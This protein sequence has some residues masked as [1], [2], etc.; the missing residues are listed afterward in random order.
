MYIS[1]TQFTP[2]ISLSQMA[3]MVNPELH[4]LMNKI[5]TGNQYLAYYINDA[6]IDLSVDNFDHSTN[7]YKLYKSG[8]RFNK[9]QL[10][11]SCINTG[12]IA[13][14]NNVINPEPVNS[15][16]IEGYTEKQFFASSF[17]TRKGN[18]LGLFYKKQIL[19]IN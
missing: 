17:G 7:L 12:L 4:K 1:M 5:P 3:N 8:S 14:E 6:L 2:S 10:S 15:S 18:K 13:D 11:R 19:V 16:L 9:Q